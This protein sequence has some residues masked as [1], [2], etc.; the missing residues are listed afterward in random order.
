MDC[1]VHFLLQ[2]N[3][4]FLDSSDAGLLLKERFSRYFVLWYALP[5][6]TRVCI[7]TV[8]TDHKAKC[9]NRLVA[10]GVLGVLKN[11][12]PKGPQVLFWFFPFLLTQLYFSLHKTVLVLCSVCFVGFET[13]NPLFR[14]YRLFLMLA[15]FILLWVS[16]F[17]Y[18]MVHFQIFPGSNT[19]IPSMTSRSTE[20]LERKWAAYEPGDHSRPL[21]HK[22]FPIYL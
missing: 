20:T 4:F 7:C 12:I 2:I 11:P 13:W 15:L 18:G 6:V 22:K 16:K 17:P 8:S 19:P 1:R 10:N 5:I 14:V 3:T 21:S 9:V